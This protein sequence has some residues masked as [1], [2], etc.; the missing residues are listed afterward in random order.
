MTCSNE[1]VHWILNETVFLGTPT[2]LGPNLGMNYMMSPPVAWSSWNDFS[3]HWIEGIHHLQLEN[4]LVEVKVQGASNA[5]DYYFTST[6]GCYS[7]LM[8]DKCVAKASQNWR[9][10]TC[11]VN[12][13]NIFLTT[14]EQIPLEVLVMAK[15]WD[16]PKT[17]N[18]TWNVT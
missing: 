15:R 12:W 14:M 3:W 13:Y 9:H 5:M 1:G 4:K 18:L 7:E 6:L 10:K 11:L 16:I 17:C 2:I 8:R